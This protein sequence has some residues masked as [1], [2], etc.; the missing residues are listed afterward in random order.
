MPLERGDLLP[1]VTVPPPGPRSRELCRNLARYEAP[2]A[3][4]LGGPGGDTP[5][6]V[7]AEALGS[8]V[9]D[10]DGNRYVDLTSGFGA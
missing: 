2:G 4:T 1:A 5:S 9:L 8:N 3:N 6:V 7:W 10:V